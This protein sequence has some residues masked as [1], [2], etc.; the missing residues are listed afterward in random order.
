[1]DIKRTVLWV[2]FS[3]SLLLLWDGWM[4]HNGHQSMFFPSANPTQEQAAANPAAPTASG[5]PRRAI[6]AAPASTSA[7]SPRS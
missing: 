7:A 2:V 4:R 6:W 5:W 3:F 1:M